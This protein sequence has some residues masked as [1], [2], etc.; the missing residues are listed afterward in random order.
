MDHLLEIKKEYKNKKKTGDSRYIYQK[1]LDKTCFQHD[2]AY[3]DFK[4]LPRRTASDKI[5]CDKVFNVAKNPKHDKYQKG[6]ASMVY[7]LFDKDSSGGGV[8]SAK[9]HGLFL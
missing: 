4:D 8:K 6:L 3:F 2:L 9:M 7:K 5:L 1:E